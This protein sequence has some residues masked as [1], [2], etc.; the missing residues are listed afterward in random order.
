MKTAFLMALM[1]ALVMAVGGAVG[2]RSGMLFALIFGCGMNIYY[3]WFSDSMVLSHYNAKPVDRNNAPRLYAMVER[4]ASKAGLPMPKVYI[5]PTDVPNAFATGRDPQHAAVAV[6]RGLMEMLSEEE[7]AGVL[8]HELSHVKH[9]DILIST[10]A[11]CM[12]SMISYLATMAKW[13]M[14]FGGGSRR[15]DD[16]NGGALGGLFAIIIAPIAAM[17]IQMGISR[18]REYEADKSG[19]EICGN[20]N[21]L[22]DALLKIEAYAHRRVMPNANEATAHMF[23][24][25]P[26]SGVDFSSLFS[27]HPKTA[28]RVA[29]L[30]EQAA[31]M[32]R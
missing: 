22:A 25:N 12:A 23:I 11:A 4:L 30:R 5:I 24:I 8:A 29:R 26:L 3:Y 13:A 32:R 17:M 9:R 1:T 10:V 28:E 27:T 19:G 6:N 2:G 18:S 21:A 16:D 15:D 20:P 31:L 7:L 14:I